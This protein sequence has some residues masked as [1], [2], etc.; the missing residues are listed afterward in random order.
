M[1]PHLTHVTEATLAHDGSI[2]LADGSTL[3][4]ENGESHT[5]TYKSTSHSKALQADMCIISQPNE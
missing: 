3:A 5:V 4:G 1:N 2:I